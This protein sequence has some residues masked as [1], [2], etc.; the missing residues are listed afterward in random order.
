MYRKHSGFTLLELSIVM[1]IIG[2]MIAFTIKGQEMINHSRVKSLAGDFNDIQV[3]LYGYQDRYHALPGDDRAASVHL[4]ATGV[5]ILDGNGNLIIDGNWNSNSGESFNL[6]QH[7]RLAGLLTG[8]TDISLNT[9]VPLN[10]S[11]GTLGVTQ[12]TAPPITGLSG[13]YII[14]SNNISGKLVKQLDLTLDDGNTAGGAM[15]VAEANNGGDGI[16]SGNIL[17]ND[18]YLACL[19]V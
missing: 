7:V 12:T 14:C 11:G 5:S 10:T 2:L 17:D 18:L 9:Y 16:N 8:A 15:M 3:A 1:T 13:N 19:A 6:W 4:P